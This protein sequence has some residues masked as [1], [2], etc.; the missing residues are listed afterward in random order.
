MGYAT[1]DGDTAGGLSPLGGID[2][3]Y[4][5]E[6]LCWLEKEGLPTIGP[7]PLYCVN[8][9]EPTAEHHLLQHSQTKMI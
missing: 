3:A 1:M 8:K 7:L 5:R 4:L 2:K 9:Q 6:W